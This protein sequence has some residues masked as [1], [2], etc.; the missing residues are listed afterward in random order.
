MI[1]E[2]LWRDPYSADLTQALAR[3]YWLLNRLEDQARA[4]AEFAR[5]AHNSPLVRGQ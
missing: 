2:A 4:E 5:L 3:T 1:Q